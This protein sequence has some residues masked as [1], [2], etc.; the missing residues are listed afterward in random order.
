MSGRPLRITPTYERQAGAQLVATIVTTALYGVAAF[1]IAHYFFRHSRSDSWWIK[2]TIA[3]L[4][5]LVTL[6]AA[7][8]NHQMY[9]AFVTNHNAG[10]AALDVIPVSMPAKTACIF[11]AAFFAQIFYASRIWKLGGL[12]ESRF[13]H[14]FYPIVALAILQLG[15]GLIQVVVMCI[16]KTNTEMWKLV[17]LNIRSMYINGVA[18]AACDVLITVA[19]VMIFRSTERNA[20]RRTQSLVEKL[21]KYTINRG[22]ITSVFAILSIL[23]YDFA[24]GTL[25]YLIPFSSNT[26]VY[27][28]SVISMLTAR[29]ELRENMNRSFHISE[30]VMNTVKTQ[31]SAP[32][33]GSS[34]DANHSEGQV[35]P[36]E[37]GRAQEP[38]L[39]C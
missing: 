12:F 14:A 27:I 18:T 34:T 36:K 32:A 20:T 3:I 33:T 23:L 22:I 25:Y 1:M 21:V 37:S 39:N 24:S 30:L 11:L 16:A 31:D 10:P 4:G 35:E 9:I 2:T 26:H 8:A 7:F 29:E 38:S 6:E 19:L 5:I 17:E 15:G 13:R 28:I